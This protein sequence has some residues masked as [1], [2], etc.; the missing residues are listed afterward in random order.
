MYRLTEGESSVWVCLCI[1]LSASDKL[2]QVGYF[3]SFLCEFVK[4]STIAN[5]VFKNI[6]SGT[7]EELIVRSSGWFLALNYRN[8]KYLSAL[9]PTSDE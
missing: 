9:L 7:D 3:E 2:A 6:L 5:C 4:S 8:N 1:G